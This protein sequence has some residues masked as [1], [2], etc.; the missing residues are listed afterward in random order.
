MIRYRQP[1]ARTAPGYIFKPGQ[2]T[3]RF[4]IMTNNENKPGLRQGRQGLLVSINAL[5][6][7][8][9]SVFFKAA[10]AA[11]LLLDEANRDFEVALA[12]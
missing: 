1:V 11:E 2:H 9:E 8:A 10:T 6:Y 3:E 5:N 7:I 12:P 4:L